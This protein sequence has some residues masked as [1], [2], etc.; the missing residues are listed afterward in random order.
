MVPISSITS[1]TRLGT[2]LSEDEEKIDTERYPPHQGQKDSKGNSEDFF[3]NSDSPEEI[4]NTVLR[5]KKPTNPPRNT[6]DSDESEDAK[7]PKVPP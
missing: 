4:I 5:P 7:P 3:T 6:S 2:I 1:S